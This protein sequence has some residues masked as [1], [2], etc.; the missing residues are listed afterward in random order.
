M[1]KT[2]LSTHAVAVSANSG[3]KQYHKLEKMMLKYVHATPI[4]RDLIVRLDKCYQMSW[5]CIQPAIV[6][7]VL[8]A[9][10]GKDEVL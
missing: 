9:P 6:T 8:W 3:S 4:L 5:I 1:H 2:A 10:K 7:D